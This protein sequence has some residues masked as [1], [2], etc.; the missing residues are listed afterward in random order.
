VNQGEWRNEEKEQEENRTSKEVPQEQEV[1]VCAA[2]VQLL[3]DSLFYSGSLK[4]TSRF[5]T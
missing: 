4:E 1:V 5:V 3:C 2:L